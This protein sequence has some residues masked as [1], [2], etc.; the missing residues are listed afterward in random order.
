[1]QLNICIQLM[2]QHQHKYFILNEI[3]NYMLVFN[4]WTMLNQGKSFSEKRKGYINN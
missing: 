2:Q 4:L 1:M 3:V